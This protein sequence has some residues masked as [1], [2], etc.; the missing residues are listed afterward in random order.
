MTVSFELNGTTLTVEESDAAG[1]KRNLMDVLRD[2]GQTLSVK[3]GCAPQGQCGCCTV[4]VDGKAR[5]SCVT[6]VIRVRGKTVETLEGLSPE[7]GDAYTEAFAEAGGSQCGFCTPGIV[8]RLEARRRDERSPVGDSGAGDGVADGGAND[9]VRADATNALKA[10]LCRCTGWHGIVES[11]VR[12]RSGRLGSG[13]HGDPPTG[14]TM[15]AVSATRERATLESGLM[16]RW[17]PEVPLGFGAFAIDTVPEGAAVAVLGAD[18]EWL[19]AASL[20]EARALSR[21]VQ[22]RRSTASGEAPIDVPPGEWAATLRTS[23]V[24]P[25]YLET[26]A[27]WCEPGGKPASVLANAGAFGAKVDSPL[28]AVAAE[29]AER[30]GRPVLALWSREDVIRLGSKRPP[31]AIGVN[32]DGTGVAR[33]ARA[34]GIGEAIASVAPGLTIEQVDLA[35]PPVSSRHRAAGWLEAYCALTAAGCDTPIGGSTGSWNEVHRP[36]GGW[37]RCRVVADDEG[38][39]G[40]GVIEVEVGAGDPLDPVVIRSFV[41]GAV[42]MAAGLVASESITVD[43]DGHVQDLTI[44]SL[45]ILRASEMPEVRISIDSAGSAQKP[46][47][48]SDA[49]FVACAAAIWNH[50]GRPGMWPTLK[51]PLI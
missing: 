6:P 21:K 5:V 20:S 49:V 51:Q 30:H 27:A 15:A 9:A 26:D 47:A 25:A 32:P 2:E 37:A 39:E 7:V 40:N 4:L 19:L 45:G 16:Q 41:T 14:R 23:W 50:H 22:G 18:G 44:R 35:G 33:V 28:P 48:V 38:N 17:V 43:D 8:M 34:D 11:A 24:E 10:H 36:D 13:A 31:V 42:H 3:D 1:N 12:L 29:L 46:V